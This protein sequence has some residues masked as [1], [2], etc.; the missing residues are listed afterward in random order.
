MD[1]RSFLASVAAAAALRPAIIDSHVHFYDPSRPQGVPWPPKDDRLLYRTVLPDEYKRLAQPHGVA[2][3]IVI[4]AS[5][6]TE[7][8]QW[9]LDLAR[10]DPFLLAVVGRLDPASPEFPRLL[11][12]FAANPLFRGIRLGEKDLAAPGLIGALRRLDSLGLSL[13][14]LGG[15]GILPQAVR[16][17]EALPGLRIIVDH[18]PFDEPLPAELGNALRPLANLYCKISHLPRRREGAP[19]LDPAWYAPLLDPLLDIF[20][21]YR[22]VYGSNWPVSD[23]VAPFPAALGIL[24]PY[25]QQKRPAALS[26]FFRENAMHFYRPP[27]APAGPAAF[28]G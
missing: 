27:R 14:L 17:A 4:E 19:V 11:R 6:W 22:V 7:D 12:R 26:R 21:E 18:M 2:G 16:L 13:D 9:L 10:R 3:V 20:G 24:A 8:N 25:F 5:P 15:P 23:R 28:N 1:R